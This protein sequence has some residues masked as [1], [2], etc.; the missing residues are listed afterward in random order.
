MLDVK[1]NVPPF[2]VILAAVVSDGIAPK[3]LSEL[4][5]NVPALTDVVPE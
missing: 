1:S 2:R 4:I 3:L 5:L